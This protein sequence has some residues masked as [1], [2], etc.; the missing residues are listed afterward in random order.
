M[1]AGISFVTTQ[2]DK[3]DGPHK[4]KL[5]RMLKWSFHISIFCFPVLFGGPTGLY[6]ASTNLGNIGTTQLQQDTGDAVT[7]TCRGFI[8]AGTAAG[9]VPLFD[10]CRAM[11]HS[12]N[13]VS[14]SG[15]PTKDSL[16]LGAGDLAASLQQIAT[17][18]LANTETI[19]T[20]ISN[21]RLN[22]LLTRLSEVRKGVAGFSVAGFENQNSDYPEI[23]ADSEERVGLRGGAAG[24]DVQW[25]KWSVF[26][27]ANIGFGEA[28]Q[29]DQTDA[30][31]YDAY[32]VNFGV[33]YR[34]SNTFIVGGMLNYFST[35]SEFDNNPTVSGG[36]VDG[37]GIGGGVY[38]TYFKN[39]FYIDALAAYAWTDY[40]LNRSIVIPSN[41]GS[42]SSI[43]EMAVASPEGS[44]I[45]FSLGGG[46]DF[47][48][49]SFQYGPYAR[50]VY[51]NADVDGYAESGADGSGLNLDVDSQDWSSLTSVLGGKIS[52]TSNHD[53]GVL[54]PYL[55]A[56]WIHEFESDA[57]EITATY[58]A[59]PRK[60]QLKAYTNEPDQDYV[61]LGIGITAVF[62]KNIQ[63]FINYD[64]LIGLSDLESHV[65]SL[66]LRWEF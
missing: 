12:G 38:A 31:D 24:D 28:D 26:L 45:T 30:F 39:N 14:N 59:D 56:G 27:T 34:L 1:R 42:V 29:T 25:G 5:N 46:Y 23:F 52:I 32:G 47:Q 20:E 65:V 8:S 10:T 55:Q 54:V 36:S 37:E 16:G 4:R 21:N 13:A 3:G 64:T 7:A 17:E 33:D 58:V 63:A 9:T 6:A 66:G 48:K 19:G 53:F 41:S 62:A 57:E 51:L 43:N 44:D 50:L 61:E 11:V 22:S 2:N 15:G 35:D 49:G 18:E 40:D 60:N